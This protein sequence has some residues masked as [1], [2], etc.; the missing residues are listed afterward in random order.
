[1]ARLNVIERRMTPFLSEPP[2]VRTAAGAAARRQPYA[3]RRRE[4]V[5]RFR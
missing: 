1:M 4:N 3:A 2:S 5:T